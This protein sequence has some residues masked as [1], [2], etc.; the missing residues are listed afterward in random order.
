MIFFETK[1]KVYFGEA[2]EVAGLHMSGG[3]ELKNRVMRL[4]STR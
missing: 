1:R 2:L 4:A 3:W